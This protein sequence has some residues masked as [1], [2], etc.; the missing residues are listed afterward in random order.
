MLH[1][2]AIILAV[3]LFAGAAFA[4]TTKEVSTTNTVAGATLSGFS[5]TRLVTVGYVSTAAPVD[6][7]SIAAKHANGNK[8]YGTTSAMT[9]NFQ[10]DGVPGT[11]L[12]AAS[13]PDAPASASDSTIP[14]GWSPM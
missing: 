8:I 9:S 13:V 10:R 5:P 6:R 3:T 1:K 2:L 12:Q 7:Y 11:T 4:S 14:T